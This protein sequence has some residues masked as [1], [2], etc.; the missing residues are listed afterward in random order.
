MCI[1]SEFI[2][3]VC[4]NTRQSHL[5]YAL[6]PSCP[7]CKL[8]PWHPGLGSR[9]AQERAQCGVWTSQVSKPEGKRPPERQSYLSGGIQPPP[10][11]FH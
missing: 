10:E 11:D 6:H 2:R 4:F 9:V 3:G 1:H 8:I 5:T 7:H